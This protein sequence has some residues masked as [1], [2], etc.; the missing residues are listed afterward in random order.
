MGSVNTHQDAVLADRGGIVENTHPVHASVVDSSG[1]VLFSLGNPDRLTLCRSAAKPAQALAILETGAFNRFGF[2]LADLALM[3]ASHNCEDKHLNRARA[4]LV[5]AQAAESDLRCGGHPSISETVNKTWARN[6]VEPTPV[7]N[8]CSG[9]HAGMLGAARALGTDLSTYHQNE[10]PLQ[11]RVRKAV[12]D[13]S[14]LPESEI[15]WAIDG[16]NLPAPALPLPGMARLFASFATAADAAERGD[17]Q[18]TD[19][20][21]HQAKIFAAMTQHADMVAGENRFCTT[22][23]QGFD[24]LAFGKVGADG[25][26]AVGVRESPETRRLGARG[27]LGIAVKIEDGSLVIL[28]AVVSEILSQLEIGSVEMRD[29]LSGFHDSRRLN[30]AGVVVGKLIFDFNLTGQ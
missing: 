3:C 5:K 6:A 19:R 21:R 24:G 7:Y 25:F 26:Y 15:K 13:L 28:Y 1:K 12:E 8:N 17:A 29:K 27:S 14:G 10:H 4:M 22:F 30:T 18:M 23:M 9:K 11:Q 2:D 16:C 20:E